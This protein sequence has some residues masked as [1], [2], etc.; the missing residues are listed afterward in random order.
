MTHYAPIPR[1]PPVPAHVSI[2]MRLADQTDDLLVRHVRLLRDCVAVSQ[3]RWSFGIEAAVVLPNQMFL[4]CSFPDAQFGIRSAMH[5]ITKAFSRHLPEGVDAI[6]CKSNEMI[7][8]APA[9]VPLRRTFIEA[10]PVRAG[11]VKRPED[12]PF[13][14]AHVGVALASEMG[15]A[16][17]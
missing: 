14:S 15:V 17:A 6:W 2:T 12:W 4:L 7:E 11:L 9:V 8:V 10:A 1:F 16:V 5:L 13:S 3:S